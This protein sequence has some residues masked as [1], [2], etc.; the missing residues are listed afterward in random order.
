MRSKH[1]LFTPH[2]FADLIILLALAGIAT[3]YLFDAYQASTHIINLI[4]I[5][6][7]TIV[8]FV[9]CLLE[10]IR[11]I[12]GNRSEP[13]ELESV[14][15]VLPVITLFIVYVLTLRWLGFD[16]GTF[17]FISLFLYL[18]SERHWAW[19]LGYS[20]VFSFLAVF[21]FSKMLPYPMPML[22]LPTA[23]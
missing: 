6:P 13:K 19:L 2:Q 14:A 15:S 5:A 11:Q 12:K 4:L 17:I 22:I 7:A 21:A 23:Y 18:H 10:F 20:L 3:W 1:T 16:F 8:V 9:L